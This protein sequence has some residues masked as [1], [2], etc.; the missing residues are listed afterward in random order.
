MK[1]IVNIEFCE[2]RYV[3]WIDKI[4]GMVVEASSLPE[5]VGELIT[6]LKVKMAYDYGM[7]IEE[8]P[9]NAGKMKQYLNNF[10]SS[11]PFTGTKEINFDMSIS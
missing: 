1:V 5:V 4:K 10:D 11:A 7:D 8:I 6:S 9:E 2:N 3:A